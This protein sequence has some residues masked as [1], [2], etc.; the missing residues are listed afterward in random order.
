MRTW[1]PA[2]LLSMFL[3]S[4]WL[5]LNQSVTPSTWAIGSILAIVAP[6]VA[7]NLLPDKRVRI[8]QPW[9]FVRLLAWAGKEI[10]RSCLGVC[11]IIIMRR[12]R[13]LNSEFIRVPLDI[14]SPYGLAVLAALINSTPG[15]VW[16]EILPA[17]GDLS[18]HVLDLH[19]EQWWIDTIKTRYEAPLRDIFEPARGDM[20]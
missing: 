15:T 17:S 5:L 20:E 18:L 12:P 3:L 13:L 9:R 11:W 4:L 6:K 19:D 2:P 16:I 7:G 1:L 14:Q 10:V 8:Y